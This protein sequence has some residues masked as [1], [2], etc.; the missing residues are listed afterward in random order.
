MNK[1][2]LHFLHLFAVASLISCGTKLPNPPAHHKGT[3]IEDDKTKRLYGYWVPWPEGKTYNTTLEQFVD[4]R[5]VCVGA[6]DY[7]RLEKYIKSV[8]AIIKK[9]CPNL[10]K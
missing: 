8:E 10:V 5:V 1:K 3:L 6:D 7:G 9:S 4:R 2:K